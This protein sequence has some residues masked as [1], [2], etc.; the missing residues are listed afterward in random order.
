L[1]L[2]RGLGLRVRKNKQQE[3]KGQQISL[4]NKLI[5]ERMH[6]CHVFFFHSQYGARDD[7]T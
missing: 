2:G 4:R 6:N 1:G 3:K 7:D 5:M